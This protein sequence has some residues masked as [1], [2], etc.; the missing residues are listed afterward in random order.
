MNGKKKNK[1]GRPRNKPSKEPIPVKGIIDEPVHKNA[2]FEL[3]Y[4]NPS[5]FKKCLSFFITQ[6]PTSLRCIFKPDSINLLGWDSQRTSKIQVS[7]IPEK[8]NSY[9]CSETIEFGISPTYLQSVIKKIDKNYDS[10]WWYGLTNTDGK[11]YFDL[12]CDTY[13]VRDNNIVICSETYDKDI[14]PDEFIYKNYKLSFGFDGKYFNKLLKDVRNIGNILTIRQNGYDAPMKFTYH[15]ENGR[16]VIEDVFE[17]KEKIKFE[18]NLQTQE[19][20]SCSVPINNW[21]SVA[22]ATLP[23]NSVIIKVDNDRPILTFMEADKGT[24]ELRVLTEL[25]SNA[26]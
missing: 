15:N 20:F 23:E 24:I 3:Y 8:L 25:S 11:V 9:Y 18:C 10:I 21:F 26:D 7:I 2:T 13:G 17:Q 19:I 14:E 12:W 16:H 5:V 6:A 22:N 1:P 4:A